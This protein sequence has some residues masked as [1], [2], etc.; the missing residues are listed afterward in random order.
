[1]R[2]MYAN[3][4]ARGKGSTFSRWKE[5]E[6]TMTAF[7]GL[8]GSYD[9]CE[10]PGHK[11]AQCSKLLCKFDGGTLHLSGARRSSWCSLYNTHL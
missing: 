10:K 5:R 11:K 1:M 8:E 6:S 3:R 2:N 9:Y 7:L 4:V